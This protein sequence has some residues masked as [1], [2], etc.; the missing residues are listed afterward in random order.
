MAKKK[1]KK[2]LLI[3]KLEKDLLQAKEENKNL[4]TISTQKDI[5]SDLAYTNTNSGEYI[6]LYKIKN[7]S[8]YIP[9]WRNMASQH[10]EVQEAIEEIT[11]D[12]I[13]TNDLSE[14][15]IQLDFKKLEDKKITENNKKKIID[16][17]KY[18]Y[19]LQNLDENLEVYFRRFYIDSVLI[20]EDIFDN[21][22]MKGGI[23]AINILDPIG[24][25]KEYSKK[26]KKFIYYKQKYDNNGYSFLDQETAM[27]KIW[28]DDQISL[29]S[30]GSW[31]P[32]RKMYMSYLNYAVMPINKLNS[33]ETSIIVY[34]L[35]RSTERMVYY[36]DVGD[37]PEKKALAKIQGIAKANSSVIKYDP[38]T[39]STSNSK[40]KIKLTKDIY[41]GRRN[42][43]KGTQ[44][45]N[46]SASDM[47]IGEMPILEYFQ[48]LLYRSLKVPRLRKSKE[49]T[50]QFGETQEIE[51]EELSFFKFITK[52]RLK[53]THLFR[54]QL[55]KHLIAKGICSEQEWE[56]I[57]KRI[58][59]FNF[60][61]NNDFDEL[62]R[63]AALRS[64][65]EVLSTISEYTL[66]DFNGNLTIFSREWVMDNVLKLTEEQKEEIEKQLTDEIKKL[67]KDPD[68]EQDDNPDSDDDYSPPENN[69]KKEKKPEDDEDEQDDEKD[70]DGVDEDFN[71]LLE[72][73]RNKKK[74][75]KDD[76]ELAIDIDELE[77]IKDTLKE[78]DRIIDPKNNIEMIY[79]DGILIP[80]EK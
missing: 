15:I 47:N 65:L 66:K 59:T 6:E 54:N 4:S 41:L 17:W 7:P 8:E 19:S 1:F 64:R 56:D 13:V 14:D 21:D 30:S 23:Q 39:G 72:V 25:V 68:L 48:D 77:I 24:M 71:D 79:K 78:G 69:T 53:L 43:E 16:E 58:I 62:K 40:D 61:N 49:A 20:S 60:L 26:R 51:R 45:E 52:L 29:C 36:I 9:M 57:Y 2:D 28:V 5:L 50:F 3:E 42:G 37:M 55:K 12:A 34:A 67:P 38:A 73:Y 74:L 27:K 46:L 70:E 22:N 31:D 44:I 75:N 10:I 76:Q 32:A 11:N 33:I 80:S 18:L 35:T 63:I